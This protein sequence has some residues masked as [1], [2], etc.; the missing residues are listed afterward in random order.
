M[1]TLEQ[2]K[3][4]K[5]ATILAAAF[6]EFTGKRFDEVKL[7]EIAARAGVG[8]GTLYLYFKNKEDLFVQMALEGVA[9]MVV[10]IHEITAM[11]LAFRERYFLFGREVGD[12]VLKRAVMF[13]L[14]NQAG[15]EAIQKEFMK[16]HRNLIRSARGLLQAGVDEGVFR[17]DFTIA[18]L[19]CL[20]IGPL[21]F[22]VRLN[23]YNNDHIEVDSLLNLFWAAA[24][25]KEQGACL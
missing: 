19:H 14:M 2:K 16:Q 22:R 4:E 21:L 6:S 11:K 25:V 20:F 13:Q 18:D 12:F 17:N 10:R 1:I 9:Q 8:K 23:K 15:S 24:A 7:D 3:E 5:R